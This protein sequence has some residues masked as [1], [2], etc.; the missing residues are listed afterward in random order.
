MSPRLLAVII[1]VAALRVEHASLCVSVSRTFPFLLTM[2]L[3][4]SAMCSFLK[5]FW[6]RKSIVIGV[7][8]SGTGQKHF[9]NSTAGSTAFGLSCRLSAI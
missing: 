7:F 9:L 6:G 5:S 4:V 8:S 1:S 3:N 2:Q